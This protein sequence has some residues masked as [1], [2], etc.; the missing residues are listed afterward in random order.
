[1]G[2]IY[3]LLIKLGCSPF[4]SS[5]LLVTK[6][7]E[8][9]GAKSYFPNFFIEMLVYFINDHSKPEEYQIFS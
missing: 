1:M 7:G 3:L 6:V 4:C 2:V 8:G 5:V 9:G